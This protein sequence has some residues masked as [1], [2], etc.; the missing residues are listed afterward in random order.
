MVAARTAAVCLAALTLALPAAARAHV[1]TSRH[2]DAYTAGAPTG[3]HGFLLRPDE[4]VQHQY[5]RT[6]AFAWAPVR[7][8]MSYTFQLANSPTFGDGTIIWTDNGLT[9]PVA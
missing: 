8:A 2:A 9:T 6:P 7:G 5:S 1:D 3:L 4:Q